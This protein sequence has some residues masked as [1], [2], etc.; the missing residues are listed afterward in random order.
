M[1][2]LITPDTSPAFLA[3][4]TDDRT[5]LPENSLRVYQALGK[6]GV[7]AELHLYE[8]GGHGFGLGKTKGPV[9]NWTVSCENWLRIHGLLEM[10]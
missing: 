6:A 2:A 4:A 10:K 7:A 9:A 1:E 3:G 5:V 8:R